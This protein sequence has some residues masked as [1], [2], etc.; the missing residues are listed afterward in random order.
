MQLSDWVTLQPKQQTAIQT[1]FKP[2]CKY[3][4][5]GGAMAGGKSFLLRWAALLYLIFLYKKYDKTNI[6]IGLFSE[7]YPTLKDR[8]ISKI[9]REFP[10]WLGGLKDDS[11][12][13]LSFHLN[14]D[15]GGGYILLR[16]LDD[17]SKYMS[18][19]FA[20]IFVDELTRN[21]EQTFQDL[22]NRLRYAGIEQVKFMGATNPGGVGHGWVRKLFVDKLSDDPE[23]KRFFYV[24]ANAYDNKYINADY[25]KQLE[26][27]PDKKKKAYL[28]GSWDV[29]EGQI[30][31]EFN[32]SIHV[33]PPFVPKP[34]IT[35]VG[36][37]DWGYSAPAVLLCGALYPIKFNDLV[38]NRLKIYREI[39]GIE[40]TPKQWAEK[41]KE[42]FYQKEIP[43]EFQEI[44][45]LKIYGDPAMFNKLQDSSFSIADQFKR[46]GIFIQ[47]STNNRL[48][49]I[50]TIHNWLS[51]A[52][53]G[54]PYMQI[55]EN[56]RNLIKT[57]PEAM[58][59]ENSSE[60]IDKT[61]VDDHWCF[62]R[63]TPILT[64]N[65][66]T[67]IIDIKKGDLVWT[68]LGYTK[69]LLKR[70]TGYKSTWKLQQIEATLNHKFL[71]T[72]GWKPL[73]ELK[74]TKEL[75]SVWSGTESHTGVTQ[76][77]QSFQ[78]GHIL[79]LVTRQLQVKLHFSTGIFGNST[80]E[81]YPKVIKFIIKMVMAGIIIL[82]TLFS[83]LLNSIIINTFTISPQHLL[84]K[85]KHEHFI[86]VQKVINYI[87]DWVNLLGKIKYGWMW[88]VPFVQRNIKPP[89]PVEVNFAG[90]PVKLQPCGDA[91]VYNLV[92]ENGMFVA[93]GYVTSNCD[94]L[95][96]LTAM[97]KW[98]NA[99]SGAYSHTGTLING[100]PVPKF[101]IVDKKGNFIPL[102]PAKFGERPAK[103][104]V[105][106]PGNS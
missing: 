83:L 28:Y 21:E 31:T 9:E 76:I 81:R 4:L 93:S 89:F 52:P 84:H 37:L 26:S 38:F 14:N 29:F 12:H 17:P 48:T 70:K 88:Y 20:G 43:L 30:F 10:K 41:W 34:I 99:K 105:Y 66:W 85:T 78:I 87:K 79:G 13:G 94:A 8:Q 3:L 77:H 50:T 22:R 68:P 25:I 45:R 39:D 64:N 2:E 97:V 102:D 5:Y 58:Y 91:E 19:E 75:W 74:D 101:T 23:Q 57:I 90:E 96:Y 60:D 63:Y 24:H 15:Y 44:R 42:I 65:G 54:L 1:L 40:T 104:G 92:T 106:Y 82:Q 72:S 47:K 33:I 6:E 103:S 73:K 80:L 51:M 62:P 27:L 86:G 53:D 69:V 36:G 16:N 7:D 35:L 61:W 49:S 32:R 95:R 71:T 55:G 100:L 46:E 98:I 67:P 59:D 56:C 18:T 11:I